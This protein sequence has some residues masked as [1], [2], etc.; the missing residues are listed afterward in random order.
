MPSL[1]AGKIRGAIAT[2]L[3]D[4]VYGYN[5]CIAPFATELSV[6]IP[7]IDFTGTSQ[8]FQAYCD[9]ELI[10]D[11]T[12]FAFPLL[13]LYS[14]SSDNSKPLEKFREFAGIVM[15]QIMVCHSWSMDSIDPSAFENTADCVEAAMYQVINSQT[16]PAWLPP[17][18]IYDGQMKQTRHPVTAGGLGLLLRQSFTLMFRQFV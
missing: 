14:L 10:E 16:A 11:G 18:A 17:C 4:P 6:T 5:A 12:P 8:F 13:L 1:L 7:P 15:M 9:P 3:E 2:R